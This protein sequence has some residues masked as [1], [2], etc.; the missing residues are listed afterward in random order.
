[1]AARVAERFASKQFTS[2][3]DLQLFMEGLPGWRRAKGLGDS[4]IAF[5]K[6]VGPVN[7]EV[8]WD[9]SPWNRDL[10]VFAPMPKNISY[11]TPEYKDAAEKLRARVRDVPG[12]SWRDIEAKILE[13]ATA[14]KGLAKHQKK[15][16]STIRYKPGYGHEWLEGDEA[17]KRWLKDVQAFLQREIDE[18]AKR[19]MDWTT[20]DL[21][22]WVMQHSPIDGIIGVSRRDIGTTV[23]RLLNA[24]AKAGKIEKDTNDPRAPRWLGLNWVPRQRTSW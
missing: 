8:G 16:R 18:S 5:A 21:V 20:R 22:D 15:D 12:K 9:D 3:F 17:Y 2:M 23:S 10:Y 1:M 14:Y 24:M 7:I 19:G 11:G 6:R 4:D 13:V